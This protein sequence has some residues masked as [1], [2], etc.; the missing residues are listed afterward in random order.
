MVARRKSTE[1]VNVY[2][3]LVGATVFQNASATSRMFQLRKNFKRSEV[4][5]P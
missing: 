1:K 2:D 4:V 3:K 5:N